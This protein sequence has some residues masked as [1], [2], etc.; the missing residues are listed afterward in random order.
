MNYVG[1]MAAVAPAMRNRGRSKSATKKIISPT[2]TKNASPADK[3]KDA[4][5]S[6][7]AQAVV[8]D[9]RPVMRIN[10][11]FVAGGTAFII[12]AI[13]MA[14]A[15]LLA[16]DPALQI[17]LDALIELRD[18]TG[19]AGWSKNKEGWD[20]L[21]EHRDPSKCGGITLDS[22]T[23]LVTAIEFLN[24]GMN[25]TLP[26][27]IGQFKQLQSLVINFNPYLT[28]LIPDSLGNCK[29]L[30]KL[31][32]VGNR[33]TGAATRAVLMQCSCN[34]HAP[35][36]LLV[37]AIPHRL[38]QLQMLQELRLGFNQLSGERCTA[39]AEY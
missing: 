3:S 5:L 39:D 20:E 2:S 14:V 37:G 38:G 4:G 12:A 15:G 16:D 32:L 30:K 19:Y 25:G 13:S 22:T 28:G 7:V 36:P 11:P 6:A 35:S 10:W 9:T 31:Y 29:A 21:E 33:L 27:S 23:K 1:D 24:V 17:E 18:A 34:A 8:A 26:D